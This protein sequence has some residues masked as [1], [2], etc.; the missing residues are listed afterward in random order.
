M[1]AR[2]S[3]RLVILADEMIVLEINQN[4][5]HKLYVIEFAVIVA[6]HS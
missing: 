1:L 5:V 2:S 4:F 6:Y 3:N